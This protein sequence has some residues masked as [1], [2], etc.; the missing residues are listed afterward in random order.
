MA[1]YIKINILGKEYSIKSD[2]EGHYVNQI[3][4]YLNQK[5]GEVLETTK[6]VATHN[7]LILAAMNIANDYFQVKNL[8][9]ETIDIVE[10][11]SGDLIDYI[12]SQT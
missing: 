8:N 12:D 5:I 4:E 11:K 9:E 3:G 1:G 2:V 6:T 7:V 10:S